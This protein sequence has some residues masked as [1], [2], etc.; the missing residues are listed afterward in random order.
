[1]AET[2]DLDIPKPKIKARKLCVETYAK[3]QSLNLDPILARI[4]AS[5]VSEAHQNLEKLLLPRLSYLANPFSMK[6]MA[7]A[8]DRVAL[9]ILEGECIG[10]ETDHDCDGQTSHAVI[11]DI[12]TRHFK[13]PPEK[14]R[15]YIGHRLKEG[16]GLSESVA[17]RILADVP[18]CSLLITA[19]N[20]SADEPRIARLK[21][22][23]IEVIVT[24]HHAIPTEG[25]PKSAYAC[26]NPSEPNCSYAD[27]FIA[28]CMVA[29]L[30][31]AATRQKLIELQ[32]LPE[33]AP[34]L[35]DTLDFVAVGTV[36]D[37]VSMAKSVNNRAVVSYGLQ[38]IDKGARPCWRALKELIPGKVRS[39]DLGFRIGPLL[40][41]DGRIATAFGSVTFLLTETDEEAEKWIGALQLQNETRKG[42]Q[43]QVFLE[44]LVLAKREVTLGKV[45]I[46]LYLKEGHTGVQGIVASRLTEM[47]GRPTLIF[48]PKVATEGDSL[49][50]GSA[51]GIAAFHVREA[52]QTVADNHPG[53]IKMFGGHKGAGGL[54][55]ALSNFEAFKIAFEA[56]TALQLAGEPY[57]GPV[58]WTDGELDVQ[59]LNL[60]FFDNL[61]HLEPFGREFEP[62]LFELNAIA[63]EMRPVGDGRHLRLKLEIDKQHFTGIWFNARALNENAF[64]ISLNKKLKLAC[65][66]KENLFRGKRTLDIHIVSAQECV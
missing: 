32:Y 42:L 14:I 54:T 37:C 40:N 20:G 65:S 16:Y 28:G 5:R 45:A 33:T 53:L 39:E 55:L 38:L 52:M 49:I 63:R 44:A 1:V 61:A 34:S 22:A 24:D 27:P 17:N 31:M 56:A 2:I 18:V 15:S 3:A 29:W 11:Y 59:A 9:A 43:Q 21:A 41:S 13:H 66:L 36:A 50:T 46:C 25:P 4:L 19:D 12:L 6:D 60:D 30:L 51:R 35:A 7:K 64:P 8:A 58:I 10:I 47:F 57:L 62:P 23:G 26:L 48:A